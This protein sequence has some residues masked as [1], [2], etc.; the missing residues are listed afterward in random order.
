MKIW[1]QFFTT[2]INVVKNFLETLFI[3]YD[4]SLFCTTDRKVVIIV[5]LPTI[6]NLNKII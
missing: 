6:L 1:A 5:R 4:L 3:N 2:I